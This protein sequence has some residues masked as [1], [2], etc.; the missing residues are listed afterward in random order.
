MTPK[1]PEFLIEILSH[2]T[3][4]EIN[5]LEPAY[6]EHRRRETLPI[7]SRLVS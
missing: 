5:I 2:H 6:T 7:L 3:I 1:T 4:A